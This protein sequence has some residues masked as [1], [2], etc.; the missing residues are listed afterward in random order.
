M[1]LTLTD[2][3][4]AIDDYLQTEVITTISPVT[5]KDTTQDVLTPVRRAA[6]R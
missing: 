3:P 6:S 4:A 2:I 5:P 1:S